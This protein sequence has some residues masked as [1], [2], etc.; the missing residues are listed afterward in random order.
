M[1]MSEKGALNR[2]TSG[3]SYKILLIGGSSVGKTCLLRR[4][5]EGD[6]PTN[7]KATLG[8]DFKIRTMVLDREEMRLQLW[9]TSGQERFR[10]MTQAYYRG[11]AGVVLVYDVTAEDSFSTLSDW[12]GDVGM[13][14]PENVKVILVGNKCDVEE[15]RSVSRQAGE[16]FAKEHGLK[17]FE[18]SAVTNQNVVE[19]FEYLARLLMEQE[20]ERL[21][22]AETVETVEIQRMNG[23]VPTEEKKKSSCPC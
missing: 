17:H 19:A 11:A 20:K 9:D 4:Y 13:Y 3:P 23:N 14:A 8:L 6:F 16:E 7:S 2:E 12:L 22:N 21:K 1:G 10:S 5:V 18:A 15:E